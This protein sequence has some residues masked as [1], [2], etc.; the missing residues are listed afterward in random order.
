MSIN[1]ETR[2]Y[3]LQYYRI[4]G[5]NIA[6][7]RKLQ[8]LTQLQLAEKI[9]I[10]RTHMSNIEAPNMPTSVSLEVLLSIAKELE[11]PAYKLLVRPE[12]SAV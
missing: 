6:Y 8:G 1:I 9:D 7:Y 11:L 12:D 4:I 2:S 10:S 3:M 5:L